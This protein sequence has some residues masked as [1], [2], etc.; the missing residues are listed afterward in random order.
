M[1]GNGRATM[2][3]VATIAGATLTAG[4]MLTPGLAQA[5]EDLGAAQDNGALEVVDDI[6]ELTNGDSGGH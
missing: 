1:A 2:R 5:A 6:Q 4:L 3:I